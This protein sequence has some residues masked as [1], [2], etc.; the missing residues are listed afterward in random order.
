[1]KK[2]M[3]ILALFLVNILL[4][5]QEVIKVE[6][7]REYGL[8]LEKQD[9]IYKNGLPGSD[10][11]TKIDLFSE[12]LFEETINPLWRNIKS[13]ITQYI[14]KQDSSFKGVKVWQR[15]YFNDSGF[16]D[17]FVY[18]FKTKNLPI[19]Q[20]EKFKLLVDRFLKENKPKLVAS[21][22]KYSLCSGIIL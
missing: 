18:H 19:E 20:Q 15:M 7:M 8:S 10:T 13:G 5:S 17:F 21:P 14:V 1:M 12:K 4:Y 3:L 11:V 9:S 2:I 6:E 16:I 22:L